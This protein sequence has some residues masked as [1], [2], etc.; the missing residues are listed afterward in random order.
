MEVLIEGLI[1]SDERIV[2]LAED[3]LNVKIVKQ[4]NYRYK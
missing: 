1:E 3:K 4:I 2:K